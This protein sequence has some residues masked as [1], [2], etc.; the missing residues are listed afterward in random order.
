[1]CTALLYLVFACFYV[2]ACPNTF[3]P[4]TSGNPGISSK[5]DKAAS[6]NRTHHFKFLSRPRLILNKKTPLP[7]TPFIQEEPLSYSASVQ[8]ITSANI[9]SQSDSRARISVGTNLLFCRWLV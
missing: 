9:L 8:V 3:R 6:T 4:N 2:I 5:I 1:M 7:I